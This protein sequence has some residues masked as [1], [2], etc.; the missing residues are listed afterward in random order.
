M[1][2]RILVLGNGFDIGHEL[3][4]KYSDFLRFTELIEIVFTKGKSS[5]EYENAI[6]QF[7]ERFSKTFEDVYEENEPLFHQMWSELNR[8]NYWINH[9]KRAEQLSEGWIDFEAEI[10]AVIHDLEE[11]MTQARREGTPLHRMPFFPPQIAKRVMKQKK[12]LNDINVSKM[13]IGDLNN[14]KRSLELYLSIVINEMKISSVKKDILDVRPTKVLCFNYTNT[15][16]RFYGGTDDNIDWDYIHGWAD[17][18][19][20]PVDNNMVLGIGEYL[21]DDR[22]NTDLLFLEFKKYYQRQRFDARRRS[23]DWSREIKKDELYQESARKFLFEEEVSYYLKNY[24][25]ISERES[26]NNENYE[27]LLKEKALL[28]EKNHP[29]HEVFFYGHSLGETDRDIIRKLVLN[30][31]VHTIIYYHNMTAY[32]DL[33]RNLIR[34]IGQEEFISRTGGEN[35]MIEFRR[36][37]DFVDEGIE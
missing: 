6:A 1:S 5:V 9:F 10:S 15:Y 13:L 19:R 31:N 25:P 37:S 28:F 22:K 4:T 2:E 36:Q 30:S 29:M 3:P 17:K 33:I 34:V 12:E 32:G 11:I 16:K 26:F 24:T 21:E 14:V 7:G 23:E 20:R 18:N 35:R 8:D 27:R